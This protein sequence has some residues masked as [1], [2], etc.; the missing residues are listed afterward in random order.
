MTSLDPFMVEH[1]EG[2]CQ[3]G[4]VTYRVEG[5]TVALFACHCSECQRQTSSAFGMALWVQDY[6]K[7]ILTGNTR[8]WTRVMPSGKALVG[9]FCAACGTR[10]FHQVAGQQTL[11]S[12]KPGTLDDT[13]SLAPV[14]HIWTASAQGWVEFPDGVLLYRGNPPDFT[15][16]F[17]AWRAQKNNRGGLA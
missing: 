6:R 2:R 11:M 14:A 17:D 3:C 1:L 7:E 12:V 8:S 16:I 15:A 9:E 4:D 10:L 13:R 5:E